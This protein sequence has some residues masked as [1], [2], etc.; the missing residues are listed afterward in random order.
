MKIAIT[1]ERIR[2]L[3]CFCPDL[4]TVD[5]SWQWDW[6]FH[7]LCNSS[8]SRRGLPSSIFCARPAC[9]ERVFFE[10][11]PLYPC[12]TEMADDCLGDSDLFPGLDLSRAPPNFYL[13]STPIANSIRK[14][15]WGLIARL[16][17]PADQAPLIIISL[18]D[19]RYSKVPRFPTALLVRKK[20]HVSRNRDCVCEG[21]TCLRLNLILPSPL[22]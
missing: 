1:A 16:G 18:V 7:F 2:R 4:S 14:E 9:P 15:I 17:G 10:I 8:C 21:D 20:N 5:S 12:I 13:Q 19:K 22:R 6:P 3:V 11:P